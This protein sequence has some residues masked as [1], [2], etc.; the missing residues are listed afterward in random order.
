MAELGIEA[1]AEIRAKSLGDRLL[2]SD[3]AP[4]SSTASLTPFSRR[5]CPPS[6]W[7][8]FALNSTAGKPAG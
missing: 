3:D 2:N 6:G 7:A 4:I 8:W 5:A 1:A